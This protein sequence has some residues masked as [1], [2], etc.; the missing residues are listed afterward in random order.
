MTPEKLLFALLRIA[1]CGGEPGQEIREACTPEALEQVYTLARRHDL[2]HL[3]GHALSALTLPESEALKSLRQAAAVAVFR[4][5]RFDHELKQICDTLNRAG[6]DFI[7][8]KGAVVRDLYPAPWMRTSGDID[9]LVRREDLERAAAA[10]AQELSYTADEEMNY[11]DL[12]LVAPDGVHVE[13]HFSLRENMENIDRLLDRVWDH[14]VPAEGSRY[15]LADEFLAFHLIAHMSYHFASGGCGIR[16]ILDVFLLMRH[17]RVD[18][19][20][21]R[22]YLSQCSIETFYD[23]VQELIGVWFGDRTA[24]PITDMMTRFILDGG[25]YG[26]AM[27]RQAVA[28]EREGGKVRYLLKRVFMPYERMKRKYPVLQTCPILFPLM[29]VRRWVELFFGGRFKRAVSEVRR[30]KQIDRNEAEDI[31]CLLRQLGL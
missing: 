8:L 27:Q 7:P 4:H 28:Q 18:E 19:A 31:S 17:R 15:A 1:V 16:T 12:L 25:T 21:L 29:Q 24:T 5:M 14:A 10:L 13:L 3:A 30:S 23:H 20:V 22:D 6:I 9:V 11:H 26:S 2:A